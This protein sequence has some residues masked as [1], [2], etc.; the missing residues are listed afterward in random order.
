MPRRARK[1]P[2]GYPRAAVWGQAARCRTPWST[3]G[4]AFAASLTTTAPSTTIG[5]MAYKRA[6]SAAHRR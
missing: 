1:S 5:P 4:R 6:L 3:L 2:V